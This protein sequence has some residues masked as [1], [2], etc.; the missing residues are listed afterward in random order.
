[1]IPFEK[2]IHKPSKNMKGF[3][4]LETMIVISMI[5]LLATIA[6][7]NYN[8]FRKKA[9]DATALIDTR[10]L[11]DGII[12]ATLSQEDVD[13]SK[14]NTGGSVGDTDTSGNPRNPVFILSPGVAA[15]IIGNSRMLPDG[16]TTIVSAIVWHTNG[17]LDP[18]PLSF[19]GRKEYVCDINE[20][21]GVVS[22][23]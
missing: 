7:V 22:L 13:Y 17:T 2:T 3:T 21:T 15:F 19:S 12:N 5:S 18:D 1:M 11:V 10:N 8:A 9:L 20:N 23:P 6:I 4:L 16:N 14:L